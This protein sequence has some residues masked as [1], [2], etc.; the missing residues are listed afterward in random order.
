MGGFCLLV[1][2]SY[3]VNK[4]KIRLTITYWVC[5]GRVC[6]QRVLH[7]D[8]FLLYFYLSCVKVQKVFSKVVFLCLTL[9]WALYNER[10]QLRKEA[11]IGRVSNNSR[12]CFIILFK[13]KKSCRPNR[14]I[15]PT[16]LVLSQFSLMLVIIIEI[17]E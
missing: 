11:E 2:A 17:D 14:H 7:L 16:T 15:G 8:F 3:F 12:L 4:T 5:R 1:Y 6:Y 9:Q 13:P 10:K